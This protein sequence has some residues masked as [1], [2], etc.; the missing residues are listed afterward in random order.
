LGK[1]KRKEKLAVA[2]NFSFHFLKRLIYFR[3]L[4]IQHPNPNLLATFLD[5]N[6]RIIPNPI[7]QNPSLIQELIE[8]FQPFFAL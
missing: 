6:H 3:S 1:K 5:L 8:N 2:P 7:E 4:A